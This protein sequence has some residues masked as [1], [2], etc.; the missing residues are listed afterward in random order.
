MR[1]IKL[2]IEKHLPV[3][4]KVLKGLKN[5]TINRT[6]AS[7]QQANLQKNGGDV[8]VALKSV[9]DELGIEWFL[10]YGTL[11]GACREKNFI[12]HDLD[13]DVGLFFKDYGPYIGETLKKHGFSKK[14]KFVVDNGEFAIEETYVYKDIGIDFFYFKVIDD[15]LVGYS[16]TNEQGLSWDMTVQKYGGLLVKEFIF[17]YSGLEEMEFLG[18][19]YPVPK[20]PHRHLAVHYGENYMIK[21]NNWNPSKNKNYHYREDKIGILVK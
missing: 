1:K 13:I 4:A 20:D 5:R 12:A 18:N 15:E 16:F 8:L 17:P 6:K 21:D 3:L 9:F 7:K 19:I 14:H 11:L 2:F 10:T